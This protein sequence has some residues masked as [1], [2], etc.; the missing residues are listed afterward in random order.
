[1]TDFQRLEKIKNILELSYNKM[2]IEMGFKSP[3]VFYDIKANK[4]G[5][6]YDV[7][8]KIQEYFKKNLDKEIDIQWLLTG[9]GTMFSPIDATASTEEEEIAMKTDMYKAMA[10]ELARLRKELEET[11]EDNERLKKVVD[12]LL[13]NDNSISKCKG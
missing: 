1:M 2:A 7:A 11:K 8:S 12:R 9:E 3:Q 4:C 13:D 5:I 10:E 6:S